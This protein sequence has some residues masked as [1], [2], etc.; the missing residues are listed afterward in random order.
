[1]NAR[2]PFFS[3]GDATD[4]VYRLLRDGNTEQL[5][6]WREYVES[7]W[8]LYEGHQD[9][10]FLPSAR[11][12][13]LPRFWEMFLWISMEERGCN[14]VRVG[15]A[16]SEFYIE[17]NGRRFWVEAVC[18]SGGEGADAI[19]VM[20]VNSPIA[21][22]VP[23]ESIMLR[24]AATVRE[25][26]FKHR[27]KDVPAGRASADDGYLLAISSSAMPDSPRYGGELPC[28]VRAAY[29]LGA[30][31]LPIDVATGKAGKAFHVAQDDVRKANDGMV[32]IG[33]LL[34]DSYPW[35]SGIIHS[36][37]AFTSPRLAP[38]EDFEWLANTRPNV[39]VPMDAFG[40]MRRWN[41]EG[42]DLLRRERNA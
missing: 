42:D 37:T 16:G 32:S 3:D 36:V 17:L 8:R 33:F 7:L 30:L 41:V 12:K 21:I 39:P 18:P 10:N 24:Y 13:F 26:A 31:T 29:G 38:G 40:W 11:H 9:G 6:E 22:R 2:R 28:L 25:K 23:V 15:P 34:D 1:M 5:V 14:P 35:L 4:D 27:D 20:P 19:P